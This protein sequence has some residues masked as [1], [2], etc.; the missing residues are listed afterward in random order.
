MA[1]FLTGSYHI[2][3]KAVLFI[4]P[5]F[6]FS[7]SQAAPEV[8]SRLVWKKMLVMSE[9]YNVADLTIIHEH[10]YGRTQSSLDWESIP[11]VQ[12]DDS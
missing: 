1:A 5:N 6:H 9:S 2:D 10:E 12:R 3:S 11:M 8:G 7:I 4:L